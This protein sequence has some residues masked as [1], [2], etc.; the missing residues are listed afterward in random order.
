MYDG[1]PA[2]VV[3]RLTVAVLSGGDY[4]YL[5]PFKL[6]T[7]NPTCGVMQALKDTALGPSAREAST[8]EPAEEWGLL[9]D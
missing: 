9:L 6:C 2:P 4:T 7:T 8:R 3:M 1:N 5:A